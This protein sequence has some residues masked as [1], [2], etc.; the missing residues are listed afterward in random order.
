MLFLNLPNKDREREKVLSI[1]FVFWRNTW[2]TW[3]V[4]LCVYPQQFHS[5]TQTHRI[6][7]KRW[8]LSK[9]S[10]VF[11]WIVA[12]VSLCAL[13]VIGLSR[14]MLYCTSKLTSARSIHIYT[15]YEYLSHFYT[16]RIAFLSEQFANHMTYRMYY[17]KW[18]TKD[19]RNLKSSTEY[20]PLND[21]LGFWTTRY[22]VYRLHHFIIARFH[23]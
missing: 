6:E 10:H 15:F 11:Q 17:G 2:F 1:I 16:H 19:S 13:F 14:T 18:I 9:F 4:R 3:R 7:T 21:L 23:L 5:S 12:C 8:V 20:F 22:A